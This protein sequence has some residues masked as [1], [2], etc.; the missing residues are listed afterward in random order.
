MFEPGKPRASIRA[1]MRSS[2]LRG[3]RTGRIEPRIPIV[4]LALG[5]ALAAA[6]CESSA[7]SPTPT[8]RVTPVVTEDPHL[9]EPASVDEV[10]LALQ[11]RGLDITPNTASSGPGGEPAKVISA[12]YAGWPLLLSEYSSSAALRTR[13]GFDPAR[14][15]RQGDAPIALA[16][17]NILVEFGPKTANTAVPAAPDEV[18]EE[19]ALRLVDVL[20]PLVGPLA[21]ISVEPLTLPGG[22]SGPPPSPSA[23]PSPS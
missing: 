14:P 6:A 23:A 9:T 22:A 1:A 10:F 20:D 5:V 3:P 21:Q 15:I 12:T 7:A 16:G 17:L 19:A 11:K 2:N 18:R 13:G 4:V 8:V